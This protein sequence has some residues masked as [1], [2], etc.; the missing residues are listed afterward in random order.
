MF[1]CLKRVVYQVANIEKA[2]DWYREV[3]NTEPTLDSPFA[4][5]FPVGDAELMLTSNANRPAM[6]DDSTMAYWGV[7]DVDSA[8]RSLLQSGAVPHAGIRTGFGKRTATVLDPFGNILGITRT[9]ADAAEMSAAIPPSEAARVA[10]LV[11]AL[12]ALEEREEVKGG[13][14]LAEIF[15]SE[16]RRGRSHCRIGQKDLT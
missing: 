3:L 15:L 5:I 10:A 14:F 13:D 16:D 8:Y 4:L 6:N 11:R 9:T 2:K 7:D 1:K 12:A